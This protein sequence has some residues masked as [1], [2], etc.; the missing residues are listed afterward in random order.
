PARRR[1]TSPAFLLGPTG[2]L[3]A[4]HLPGSAEPPAI[5]VLVGAAVASVLRLPLSAIVLA[6]LLTGGSAGAAP[7]IIVGVAVAYLTT[8][9]LTER[10][11][12]HSPGIEQHHD[13]GDPAPPGNPA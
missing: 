4:V 12:R 11:R 2:R 7:L 10:T 1:A 8:L 6:L 13:V 9:T 5:G 3:L